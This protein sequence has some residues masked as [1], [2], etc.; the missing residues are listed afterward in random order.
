M[1]LENKLQEAIQQKEDLEKEIE[2]IEDSIFIREKKESRDKVN[3]L[4]FKWLKENNSYY[5]IYNIIDNNVF[6]VKYW[7]NMDCFVLECSHIDNMN[8][9]T[10]EPTK[11]EK[12]VLKS[13]LK[14]H[15]TILEVIGKNT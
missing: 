14:H 12:E 3:S 10:K 4:Q 2:R 13:K 1:K 11:G 6:Y 9:N 5:F 15:L 8:K 7:D